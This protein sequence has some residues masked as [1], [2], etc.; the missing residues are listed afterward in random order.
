M[1]KTWQLFGGGRTATVRYAMQGV[2][3]RICLTNICSFMVFFFFFVTMQTHLPSLVHCPFLAYLSCFGDLPACTP[4]S[5]CHQ[6]QDFRILSFCQLRWKDLIMEEKKQLI[7][8]HS[9]YKT[10][11]L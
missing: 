11:L 8:L 4:S 2:P 1:I 6:E 7:F 10:N 9:V 5:I 3:P